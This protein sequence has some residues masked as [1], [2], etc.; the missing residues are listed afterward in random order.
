MESFAII[1][2]RGLP[3]DFSGTSGVE[4]Y[5]QAQLPKLRRVG[6]IVCYIRSWA[7]LHTSTSLPVGITLIQI[8]SINS[9]HLD[10][11]S[12]SFFASVHASLSSATVVWY[13]GIGPAFFSFIPRLFRKQ[14]YTTV[15]SLDWERKKWNAPAKAFLKLCEK[16]MIASSDKLFVVSKSLK[17]YYLQRGRQDVFLEK[18]TLKKQRPLSADIIVRK[19]GLKKN[20]YILYIGRFVPEKRL[21][22]LIRAADHITLPIVLAGGASHSL[23]YEQSLHQ[24]ATG[25]QIVFTDY[26]FGDEKKELLSN[27]RMFALPSETEGFPVSVTEALA[28]RKQCLVGDFLRGEYEN[29]ELVQ[30]FRTDDFGDFL[31]HIKTVSLKP[32]T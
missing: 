29:S 21:E 10:T 13:H 27:C 31:R 5:I 3:K 6:R 7:P 16:M 9:K 25:K 20:G 30:F 8:P 2:A 14:V 11:F 24:L 22:W 23:E 28:Y 1:G 4:A 19:H 17:T 12:Y 15:H 18:Y 32:R 26:V